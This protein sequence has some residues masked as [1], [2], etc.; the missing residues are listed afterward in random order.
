MGWREA[1]MVDFLFGLAR[2]A[3]LT[4]QIKAELEEAADESRETG[5]PARRFRDLMWTITDSWSYRRRVAGKA[6]VTQGDPNPRFVVTSRSQR[7]IFK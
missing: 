6:E 5:K 1:N 4:R 7:S 3:R 2:N